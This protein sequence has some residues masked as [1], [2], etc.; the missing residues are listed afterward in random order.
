MLLLSRGCHIFQSL[1]IFRVYFSK[2]GNSHI[3]ASSVSRA[4][5]GL[6]QVFKEYSLQIPTQRSR[7]PC[8]CP[9]ILVKRPKSHQSATSVWTTWQYHLDSHQC[10]EVSN[11]SWLHPFGRHGNM[12]GRYLEFKKISVHSFEQCGYTVRTPVRFRGELGFPS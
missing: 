1:Q 8:F 9:N 3:M 12:S 5:R 7:I 11:S 2:D 4:S 10:L 6:F